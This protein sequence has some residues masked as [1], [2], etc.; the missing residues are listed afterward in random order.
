MH[1]FFDSWTWL[2]IITG[3]TVAVLIMIAFE[4]ICIHLTGHTFWLE[5]PK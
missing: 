4:L 1:R 5:L 3:I 2:V